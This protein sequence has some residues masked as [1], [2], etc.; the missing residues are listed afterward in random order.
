M[1]VETND[2]N[3][4]APD[5]E[6][7]R[8][9]CAEAGFGSIGLHLFAQLDSTSVWLRQHADKLLVIEGAESSTFSNETNQPLASPQLCAT[10]WQTTG[11]ARR[12]RTWLTKPG[13]IT[14]SLLTETYRKPGELLGLS[15]VTGIGVANCLSRE[16][17]IQP[18]L[19]WPNDVIL[20]DAK[21][22][23]LLTEIMSGNTAG[24]DGETMAST[25]IL[26]GVGINFIHDEQ[27]KDLGIGATSLELTVGLTTPQA[28][29]VFLGKLAAAVLA[30]HQVFMEDGWAPFA[31]V[32]DSLDWLADKKVSIHQEHSTEFAVARGVNEHGALLLER[33][34]TLQPLYGGEVSIRPV[35]DH[36]TS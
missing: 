17:G 14:F 21:L 36:Q 34:G 11:I 8:Q 2:R 9:V 31:T 19:K 32:W 10:H 27:I 30:A 12:G 15:L 26:T 5:A 13:N 18:Q 22:G 25:R 23:G 16:F 7:I 33:D 3:L 28:R 4:A 6:T 24:G 1:D 29:D 35:A 20:N